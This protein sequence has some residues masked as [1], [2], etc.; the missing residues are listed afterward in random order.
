MYASSSIGLKRPSLGS[1]DV[2]KALATRFGVVCL[3]GA[4]FQPDLDE[5]DVRQ[6]QVLQSEGQGQG[7]SRDWWGKLRKDRWLR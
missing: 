6:G 3:P 4:F 1:M 5:V 7:E 2:A